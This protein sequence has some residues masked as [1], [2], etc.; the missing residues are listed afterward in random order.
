MK[1]FQKPIYNYWNG[2]RADHALILFSPQRPYRKVAC[3][4][5]LLKHRVDEFRRLLRRKNRIER[6]RRAEGVPC[7]KS[8]VERPAANVRKVVWLD[9]EMI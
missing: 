8:R 6:M 1:I 7:R 3:S 4:T 9:E 2:M 5:P